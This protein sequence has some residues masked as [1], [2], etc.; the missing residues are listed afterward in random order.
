[1]KDDSMITGLYHSSENIC[2][3]LSSIIQHGENWIDHIDDLTSNEKEQF[4]T[5]FRPY[6]P[7]IISFFTGKKQIQHGGEVP[8]PDEIVEKVIGTLDG[9]NKAVYGMAKE[10]GIVKLQTDAD[11]QGDVHPLRP[12]APAFATLGP[13]GAKISQNLSE[14]SVPL[15]SLLFLLYL[16]LDIVRVGAAASG[17]EDSRKFLSVAVAVFDF[18][19]GDWKK[20]IL[21]FMGYYSSEYT[22]MG[23]L[24][25][26]Y[27]TLFQTLSPRI[28]DNFI[29]GTF[30][31]IKSLGIGVLLELFKIFA[32]YEVRKPVMDALETIATNKKAVDTILQGENLKPLPEYMEVSYDKLGDLQGVMDDPAFICSTEYKVLL[33]GRIKSKI[34]DVLLTMQG[35]PL[36]ARFEEG[37]CGERKPFLD[38][39]VERQTKKKPKTSS[40]E[41]VSSF[42]DN[43]LTTNASKQLPDGVTK[44]IEEMRK[45]KGSEKVTDEFKKII[46]DLLPK[47]EVTPGAE[48]EITPGAPVATI[49]EHN[50]RNPVTSRANE[51]G[52]GSLGGKRRLRRANGNA[53]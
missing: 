50:P 49:A 10:T 33:D 11:K 31:A 4:S 28:R 41:T 34:L 45:A 39:L 36:T 38:L 26:I 42:I 22:F 23:Q 46:E 35:I 48:P 29:F 30:N 37:I 51:N 13:G 53:R 7:A 25:K 27:L 12:V 9:I 2:A 3:I 17:K 5:L 14:F 18:L 32:R 6:I 40:V 52:P 47:A 43:F 19:Q 44:L 1:M 21:S 16:F 20:A 8:L 24:G 15:R